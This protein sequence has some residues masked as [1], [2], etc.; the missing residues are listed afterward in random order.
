MKTIL[1]T[2]VG[3][4]VIA[5][6]TVCAVNAQTLNSSA[7]SSQ[8]LSKSI[9]DWL[10]ELNK[11]S[12]SPL[13]RVLTQY[14]KTSSAP[15]D[16][17][18]AAVNGSL[19]LGFTV[20]ANLSLDSLSNREADLSKILNSPQ[21]WNALLGYRWGAFN[22]KAGYREIDN[23][24]VSPL[25]WSSTVLDPGLSNVQGTELAGSYS[26]T[27]RA[28][29]VAG[30][31][32]YQGM[33]NDGQYSVLGITDHVNTANVGLNYGLGSNSSLNFGYE[34]VQWDFSHNTNLAPLL[35]GKPTEQ[36]ITVG[37]GHNVNKT[38]AIKL[39][40][41]VSEYNSNPS[42]SI[43]SSTPLENSGDRVLGQASFKF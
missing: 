43:S 36:Y 6:S 29:V 34:W 31:L 19:P 21:A 2:I 30:G 41:Q 9:P 25:T 17:Y 37:L 16:T 8:N 18:G 23:G 40:Y 22:F 20:E 27:P 38:T 39:L 3:M 13:Q 7:L 4:T 12:A 42:S 28:M 32:F 5:G 11:T 26:F 24:F 33:P 35:T 1:Y 10:L 15:M 14:P